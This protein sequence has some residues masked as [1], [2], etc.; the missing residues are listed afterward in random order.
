MIAK[1][2]ISLFGFLIACLVNSYAQ[3]K[4]DSLRLNTE[5]AE[6]LF[7]ENNLSLIAE[8]L[9]INQADALIL[10]AKAWPNP[11]LSIDE[12]NLNR[13]ST[14]E[15]IPP[16]FGTFAR[17]QQFTV[18]LE[19][20]ILTAQKRKKNINLEV[21]NKRLAENAFIDFLQ[22]LKLEFRTSLAHLI[23][24]QETFSDLSR[25]VE[26]ASQLL[27]A[28]EAQL[29]EG[30]ISEASYLRLK[31]LQIELSNELN[32]SLEE[33]NKIQSDLKTLMAIPGPT[34]LILKNEDLIEKTINKWNN[35]S[36][37]RLIELVDQHSSQLKIAGSV[38]DVSIAALELESAKKIPDLT[39][40]LNYDRNGSTMF[41]F[42]GA[43]VSFDLPLFDRNK[44]NIKQA[45][46]EVK[47]Q[48][49]L[50]EEK[51]NSLHNQLDEAYK[52]ILQNI[53]LYRSF[54]TDYLVKLEKMQ[55]S[56]ANNL[57]K[58]NLSLLEFLDLFD[59]FKNN[60]RLYYKI[61]RDIQLKEYELNYLV[62]NN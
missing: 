14:S 50:V 1:I 58:R 9:N 57:I 23:Y 6:K 21:N 20:L 16:L 7:L 37:A 56:I 46:L 11:N 28:Q 55:A 33:R 5:E 4:T 31:A 62:G 17:N 2:P 13:N 48:E 30:N 26:I 22:A 52:N 35:L 10:Q 25:Q 43:G 61:K 15:S 40:N 34:L 24:N 51:R 18:Q 44:G 59:S 32:E 36:Y 53:Q 47:K 39:F 27:K 45:V 3:V 49:Y 60:K 12:V 19:Q 42:F 54:D 29:R 38:K 8:R 41:N